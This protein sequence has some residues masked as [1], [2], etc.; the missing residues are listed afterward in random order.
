MNALITFIPRG[1]NRVCFSSFVIFDSATFIAGSYPDDGKSID[2]ERKYS[3]SIS[4]N[5]F[6]LEKRT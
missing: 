2:A 4:Q 6:L 3:S 1:I 5:D